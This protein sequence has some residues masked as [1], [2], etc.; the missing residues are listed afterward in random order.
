MKN[1][2]KITSVALATL[3]ITSLTATVFAE[4]TTPKNQKIQ[5]MKSIREQKRLEAKRLKEQK[6]LEIKQKESS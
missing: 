2:K 3:L 6:K 1:F 5:Q 4:E